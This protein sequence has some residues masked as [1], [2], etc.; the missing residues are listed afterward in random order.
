MLLIGCGTAI[1]KT[2]YVKPTIPPLPEKPQY[3]PVIFDQDL[4]LTE[5]YA[6][7][8]LKNKALTDDYI[9]QLIAIIE[10]VR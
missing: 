4:K 9:T 1:V 10:G 7:N 5:D 6:R 2:Q 8:L 3:Y